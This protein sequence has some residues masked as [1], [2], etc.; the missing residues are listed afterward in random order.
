M[1]PAERVRV[2]REIE[3]LRRRGDVPA[4]TAFCQAIYD[5][6]QPDEIEFGLVLKEAGMPRDEIRAAVLE[7]RAEIGPR[8]EGGYAR[9]SFLSIPCSAQG[10]ALVRWFLAGTI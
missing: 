1:T 3:R 8:D 9:F 5:G 7:Y 4:L 10:R 2:G 6:R